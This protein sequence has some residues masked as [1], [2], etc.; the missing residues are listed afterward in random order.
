MSLK[1]TSKFYISQITPP[2]NASTWSSSWGQLIRTTFLDW[3]RI[4]WPGTASWPLHIDHSGHTKVVKVSK[5][6]HWFKIS[7]I[8]ADLWPI[9]FQGTFFL[10]ALLVIARLLSCWEREKKYGGGQRVFFSI[11]LI[12]YQWDRVQ[13]IT[14]TRLNLVYRSSHW[15]YYDENYFGPFL[16]V[17]T[18]LD[19]FDPF[20]TEQKFFSKKNKL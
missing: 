10:A 11:G 9:C 19:H 8:I 16:I 18:I 17:W 14:R 6:W 3:R 20:Q 4:A 15:I 13:L 5:L 1:A 2:W 7:P 12:F